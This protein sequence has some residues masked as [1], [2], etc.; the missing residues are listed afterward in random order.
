[1]CFIF[2]VYYD[3]PWPMTETCM[4]IHESAT[5]NVYKAL[6]AIPVQCSA[7]H[8]SVYTSDHALMLCHAVNRAQYCEVYS[9]LHI[10]VT[11][12]SPTLVLLSFAGIFFWSRNNYFSTHLYTTM[13]CVMLDYLCTL[14]HITIG[15][16]AWVCHT[17]Y[18]QSFLCT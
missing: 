18:S 9:E 7:G 15:H 13:Q 16:C 10:T 14:L 3:I 2:S 11:T 5:C 17:M 4:Q 12:T 1:M 6:N 8:A